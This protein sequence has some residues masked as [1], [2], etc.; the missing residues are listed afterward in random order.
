MK[1]ASR[2][3][4]VYRS[5]VTVQI[6][7]L[8]LQPCTGLRGLHIYCITLRRFSSIPSLSWIMILLSTANSS[9][10]S[11]LKFSISAADVPALNLEG[12]AVILSHAR[13][14]A[15]KRLI[16]NVQGRAE[17][18]VGV[19]ERIKGRIASLTAKGVDVRLVYN[20]RG[21]SFA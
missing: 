17:A 7:E 2:M 16:F 5:V 19:A 18:R 10:L 15:L 3:L 11:D 13:H 4:I 6:A 9:H 21:P 8:S 20:Q 14:A 12:L 1:S